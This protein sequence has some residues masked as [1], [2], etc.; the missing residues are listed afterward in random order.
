M[1]MLFFPDAAPSEA[2]PSAVTTQEPVVDVELDYLEVDRAA[3]EDEFKHVHPHHVDQYCVYSRKLSIHR[4][5]RPVFVGY[6]L[7]PK[8]P[9]GLCH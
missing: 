3:V 8:S 7:T 2:F 1:K 9:L 4:S 6:A 5:Y